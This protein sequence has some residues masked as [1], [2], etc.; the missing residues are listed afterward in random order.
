MP[1]AHRCTWDV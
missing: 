1:A